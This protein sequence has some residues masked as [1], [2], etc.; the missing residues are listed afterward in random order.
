[1]FCIIALLVAC[2]VTLNYQT[3]LVN[4]DDK[5]YEALYYNYYQRTQLNYLNSIILSIFF[6]LMNISNRNTINDNKDVLYLIGKN[7][8]KSHQIF[9]NFYMNFKMELNED[10]S[11]LY[12]PLVTNRITVNW[13]NRIFYN[14]YSSEL[15]LIKYRIID[16][17]NHQFN[18]NDKEDCENLLLG[19]YLTKIEKQHQYMEVS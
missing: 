3:N 1:M 8:E 14:D 17:I 12:E 9:I 19:K 4:K 10:F 5:I 15:T 18:Q 6:E 2:I 16:T 11:K 13:E 7:I